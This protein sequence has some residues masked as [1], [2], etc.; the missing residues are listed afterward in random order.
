MTWDRA[1]LIAARVL[2]GMLFLSGAI[3]KTVD[4]EPAVD[5]LRGVGLPGALVWPALLYDAAAA[6]ALFAGWRVTPVALS[7]AAY[8][9]ATSVF[10]LIPDDPWQMTIFVK[11]WAIA[12]G[13]LALA[14]AAKRS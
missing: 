11:N 3:Q 12:G 6:L 13:C 14:V 10:H 1:A 4:P 5:L 9:A 2:I 7:L 8:C